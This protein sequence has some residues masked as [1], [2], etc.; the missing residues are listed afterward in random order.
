MLSALFSCHLI[1]L[2][3]AVSGSQLGKITTYPPVQFSE[4]SSIPLARLELSEQ[5]W[6]VA[7]ALSDRALGLDPISYPEA[8]LVNA[9]AHYY[10]GNMDAAERSARKGLRLDLMNQY[11]MLHL[12]LANVLARR[13]DDPG[14][15][16]AMRQYL[17]VAPEAAD[18]SLVR[19]RI[20]EKEKQLKAAND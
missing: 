19:A 15:L 16:E 6:E 14:S 18:A 10:L 13:A 3:S 2:L 1:L 9:L 12:V 11:P 5:N 8:Y 20:Q 17:K 4:S 7:A